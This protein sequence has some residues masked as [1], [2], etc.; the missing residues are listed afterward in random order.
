[1]AFRPSTESAA[2]DTFFLQ[3]WGL[4]KTGKSTFALGNRDAGIKPWPTPIYVINLDFGTDELLTR[5][6]PEVREHLFIADVRAESPEMTPQVAATQLTQMYKDIQDAL[7]SIAKAGSGTL[8]IDTATQLWQVIQKVDLDAIKRVRAE[9]DKKLFP[10]DYGDANARYRNFMQYLKDRGANVLLLAHANEVYD[11][12]G[13]PTG[14]YVPQGNRQN[15]SLVQGEIMTERTELRLA[16]KPVEHTFTSKVIFM[17]QNQRIAG[18]PIKN[19]DYPTLY[20]M[21]YGK[22]PNDP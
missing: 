9:Q 6:D 22:A 4:P 14:D 5:V 2:T 18:A 8:V 19:L 16:S 1:M 20:K 13:N 12:R 10:Y 7:S 11:A 17:R 3:V 21:T 15:R